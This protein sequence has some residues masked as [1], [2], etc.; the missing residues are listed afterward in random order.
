VT[1]EC[2]SHIAYFF[3]GHAFGHQL[4]L[5]GHNLGRVRLADDFAKLFF[6]EFGSSARVQVLDDLLKNGNSMRPIVNQFA[7]GVHLKSA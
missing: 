2:R 6:Y 1:C 5:H 3:N 7:H 4:L